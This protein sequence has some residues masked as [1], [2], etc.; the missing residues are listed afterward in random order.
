MFS[1]ALRPRALAAFLASFAVVSASVPLRAESPGF[2]AGWRRG[3]PV[4]VRGV[5]TTIVADD[6]EAKHADVIHVVRDAESGRTLRLRPSVRMPPIRSGTVVTIT[7]RRDGSDLYV[8]ATELQQWPIAT[9]TTATDVAAGGSALAGDQRT[10][11]I[12]A[13]FNDAAVSCSPAAIDAMMFG[14]PPAQSVN[15]L[16]DD[17]SRGQLSISGTVVGPYTLGN[18]ASTD[19]CDIGAWATAAEARAAASGVDVA[20][21]P[22]RL[23]VMPSPNTCPGAGFGTV[24]GTPSGAWVFTCALAGVYAHELGHNFGMDHASTPTLEYGDGT[25]PM[26]VGSSWLSG[27]NAPHLHELGWLGATTV[28][29]SGTY[30]I[31]PLAA[32]PASATAPQ[33]LTIRK[34]DTGEL[35]YVSYREPL[36]FDTQIDS[37]YHDRVSV[38][39]YRGDGSS[40]RTFLL[41]GVPDGG[42]FADHVNGITVTGLRHDAA[43]ATVHVQLATPCA[44]AAPVVSVSP[45]SQDGL[46]GSSATYLVTVTNQDSS[47]CL[48]SRFALSASAP[49]GWTASLAPLSVALE[50]GA[51]GQATLMVTTPA[52]AV[53]GTATLG[54]TVQDVAAAEHVGS[55]SASYTVTSPCARSMPSMAASPGSQ[56]A[57]PG[58]TVVYAIAVTNRDSSTCAS[59]TFG[60]QSTLPS[61]WSGSVTPSLLTLAPGQTLTATLSV[62]SPGTAVPASFQVV[63]RAADVSQAAHAGSIGVTYVVQ[64]GADTVAPT[65]PTG[66]TATVSPKQKRIALAWNPSTDNLGVAGYR[67]LRNGALVATTTVTGWADAAWATG[68]SYTYAVTAFDGAGNTSAASNAVTVKLSNKSR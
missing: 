39:R 46:P 52:D 43:G 8:K 26:T 17:A 12:V 4:T 68:A 11:V 10:L 63:A 29:Q 59:T 44:A 28:Q 41:A 53:A 13:D 62:I 67:V 1:P 57:A 65:A 54:V 2:E 45:Q 34:P 9:T 21:Y 16:Y 27:L 58:A 51:S 64:S 14:M 38:H 56:A 25:D 61:G 3:V 66:L 49:G 7:G 32:D 6:F 42:S 55:A 22:R 20:A 50:P 31:A 24:G 30:D 47:Q 35:Y 15:A 33:V 37:S 40:T 48:A 18:V 36:G 5:M 23:Y 19:P 60:M